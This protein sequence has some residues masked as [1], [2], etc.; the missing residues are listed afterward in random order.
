VKGGKTLENEGKK[1]GEIEAAILGLEGKV[2]TLTKW[3][4]DLEAQLCCI[5]QAPS[6][7]YDSAVDPIEHV[8]LKT[9]IESITESLC[10]IEGILHRLSIT[11]DA[12][13]GNL[14]LE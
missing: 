4:E 8:V 9:R 2:K 6:V 3:A 7:M 12:Q 11:V 5:S 10:V 1:T 14:R 13:L